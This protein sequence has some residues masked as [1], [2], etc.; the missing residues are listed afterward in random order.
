MALR[1]PRP[2]DL[3]AST[4]EEG[5]PRGPKR[6]R[7]ERLQPPWRPQ[8]TV[9]YEGFRNDDPLLP[10]NRHSQESNT[11][12]DADETMADPD[13]ENYHTTAVEYDWADWER[14]C[15]YWTEDDEWHWTEELGWFSEK[16]GPWVE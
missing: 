13:Q 10:P 6:P 4:L 3:D 9:T 15:T 8:E 5:G 2:R 14:R 1:L 12:T 7:L 16:S 11:K